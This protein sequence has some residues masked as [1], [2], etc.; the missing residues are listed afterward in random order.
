MTNISEVRPSRETLPEIHVPVLIS[1]Y[2]WRTS[3]WQI[4]RF[5]I[6]G[7]LSNDFIIWSVASILHPFVANSLLWAN[8]SKGCALVCTAAVSYF[9][10]RL[11]VFKNKGIS[12]LSPALAGKVKHE[13]VAAP[14]MISNDIH[15]IRCEERS[16]EN[17]TK[18][19]TS[20]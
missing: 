14:T 19:C 8:I 4:V 5:S 1:R 10:M 18:T 12:S 7:I 6:V 20:G 15:K 11:W 9:G 13:S 3:F 17:T 2:Q 16:D